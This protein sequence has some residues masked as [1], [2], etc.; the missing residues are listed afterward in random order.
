MGEV[1]VRKGLLARGWA[2][3]LGGACV[4]AFCGALAMPVAA[5]AVGTTKIKGTVTDLSTGEAVEGVD[6]CPFEATEEEPVGSCET[7]SSSGEYTVEVASG[8][9]YTLRFS[10]EGF[11]TEWFVKGETWGEA[12]SIPTGSPETNGI[13]VSLTEDGE[14]TISG[15]ATD[16]ATHQ[17]IAG[18]EVCFYGQSTLGEYTERCPATE[19]GAGGQ[20]SIANV[21]AGSY[22]V[23]FYSG[24]SCEEEMGEKIRCNQKS[25]YSGQSTSVTVR[26][27][28]ATTANAAMQAGGEIAGTVTNASITHPAIAKIEVC[29]TKVNG[30]GEVPYGKEATEEKFEYSEGCAYTNASGQYTI[31]GLSSS[32]S[33]K[34]EYYGT[35]CTIVQKEKERECPEAYVSQYYTGKASFRTATP[36]AVTVGAVTANVNESLR[37]AFPVAPANT[38]APALTGT[39]SAGSTLTCSQGTWAHEPLFLSY[40]WLSDGVA[41]AGQTTT[42]YTVQA[43]NKG[44]SL[45]CVVL[46]GNGAGTASAASNAVAIPKPKPKPKPLTRAQKL[47]K[48]L[49]VCRK[50]SKSKRAKCEKAAKKKYAPKKKGKKGKGKK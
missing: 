9:E 37:E 13:D 42:T 3:L 30:N 10:K 20:Y 38:A 39:P 21:P 35:I 22:T 25:N 12:V 17:G 41:I 36:V 32:G 40:Q 6:V 24:S 47:A 15:A 34:V 23:E 46:A 16:A 43:T 7:T 50:E 8:P 2:K 11:A 49:K 19:T 33:Y 45:S 18:V 44:D 48:A 27:D 14:G 1:D 31:M 4:V 29:A 5:D 26:D 28:Q